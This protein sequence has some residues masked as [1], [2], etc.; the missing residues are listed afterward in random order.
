MIIKTEDG[1]KT[2][3]PKTKEVKSNIKETKENE[4][5]AFEWS[6]HLTGGMCSIK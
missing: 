5:N 2:L 4:Y 6:R 3:E 1:F